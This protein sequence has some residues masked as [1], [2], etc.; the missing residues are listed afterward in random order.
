MEYRRITTRDEV[1]KGI[2]LWNEVNPSFYI[3]PRLVGQNIFSPFAGVNVDTWGIFEGDNLITF[4]LTKHLTMPISKKCKTDQGWVSLLVVNKKIPNAVS[5][6]DELF[7][8]VEEDFKKNGIKE[9]H[10]GGDPQNFLSGLPSSLEGD[11][12]SLLEKSGYRKHGVVYDL[13]QNISKFKISQK[14][15]EKVLL[16]EKDLNLRIE[17]ATQK[18]SPFLL[19]FLEKNFPER[20]YFEAENIRRIPGGIEDYWILRSNDNLLGFSRINTFKSSYLGPNI[21]W[22]F[23]WQE[24]SFGLGPIG[25][26]DNC[27][28]KGYGIYLMVNIIQ[29]FQQKGYKHMVIDWTDLVDYY[30]KIGF[31]PWIKYIMLEKKL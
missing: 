17:T 27:R 4:M 12:L 16:K 15:N 23:K 22:C 26:A 6:V 11:Y 18:T 25:I 19:E 7:K 1:Y 3:I 14:I 9:V 31:E 2:N 5:I 28:G 21:N 20:W 24:D 8:L 29:Y 30:K 13:Y 10:F